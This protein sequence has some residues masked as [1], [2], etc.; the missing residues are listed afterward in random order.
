M[1]EHSNEE[2][3]SESNSTNMT[4]RPD[5]AD[6]RAAGTDDGLAPGDVLLDLRNVT[7]R[8]GGAM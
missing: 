3:F 2:S 6:F 4:I 5:H 1:S 8:F 7:L